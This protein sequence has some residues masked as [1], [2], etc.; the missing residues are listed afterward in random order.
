MRVEIGPVSRGSASAWLDY[1]D[2]V[3]ASL[4]QI[5]ADRAPPEVLDAFQSVL[6][7]WRQAMDAPGEFHWVSDRPT[8]EV[9]FMLNALYEAGLAVEAAHELGAA[10]LR[11]AEADEFH[12]AVVNQSLAWLEAEGGPDSHL[13]D[14]L[15]EHW[16]VADD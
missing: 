4:R 14:I 8:E 11:P 15:R 13:V 12:Y 5:E 6:G 3:M 16:G 1:A 9:G 2:G 10:E 7:E